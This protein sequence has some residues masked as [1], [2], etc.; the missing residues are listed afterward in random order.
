MGVSAANIF[1]ERKDHP[2]SVKGF[3]KKIHP[4]LLKVRAST[5]KKTL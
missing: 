3:T 2:D 5:L 4:T 1:L